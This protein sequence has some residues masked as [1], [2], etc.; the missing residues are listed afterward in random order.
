[1]YGSPAMNASRFRKALV[2]GLIAFCLLPLLLYLFSGPDFLTRWRSLKDGM[3]QTEV[4]KALGAPD[5]A[6]KTSTIGAGDQPVTRWLYNHGRFTYAVDFDYI[7]A[8]GAPVVFRTE[9]L[10]SSSGWARWWPWA[11]AKARA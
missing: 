3:T 9:R 5:A 2:A 8:A 6:V 11:R 7:G 4:T 1:M 10:S